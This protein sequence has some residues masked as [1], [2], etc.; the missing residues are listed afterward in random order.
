LNQTK[1][2]VWFQQIICPNEAREGKAINQKAFTDSL[3]PVL[4]ESTIS[5]FDDSSILTL[6]INYWNALKVTWPEAFEPSDKGY[7]IQHTG[8]VYPLHHILPNLLYYCVDNE[9]KRIW[10][11]EKIASKLKVLPRA[12]GITADYWEND[13]EFG[14]LG[15]S[16]KGARIIINTIKQKLEEHLGRITPGIQL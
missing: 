9:G 4:K 3:E 7:S 6:L 15:T 14:R 5:Q 8:G 16:R 1:D 12:G 11:K 10:T 2:S 13:G